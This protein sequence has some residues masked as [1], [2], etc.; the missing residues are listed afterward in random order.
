MATVD[1]E[2][3]SAAPEAVTAKAREMA[4]GHCFACGRASDDLVAKRRIEDDIE[5]GRFR[6]PGAVRVGRWTYGLYHSE[7]DPPEHLRPHRGG[8][9]G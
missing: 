7:C 5:P 8:P 3:V 2:R 6:K 4:S 1:R 9:D